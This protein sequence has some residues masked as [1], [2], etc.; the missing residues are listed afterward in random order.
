MFSVI[1]ESGGTI[2]EF[3]IWFLIP[4]LVIY[5][6]IFIPLMSKPPILLMEKETRKE[7][8]RITEQNHI[9]IRDR[10][11]LMERE[12]RRIQEEFKLV[13]KINN[14]KLLHGKNKSKKM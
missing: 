4:L 7:I 11:F 9:L 6:C 13:D 3:S 8:E 2:R 5:T 14:M 12:S 10:T 1:V